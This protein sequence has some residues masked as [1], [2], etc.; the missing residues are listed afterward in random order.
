MACWNFPSDL[1]H[2][3]HWMF[4]PLSQSLIITF[5]VFRRFFVVVYSRSK[6]CGKWLLW[7][8]NN[9]PAVLWAVFNAFYS[10][11]SKVSNTLSPFL[12]FDFAGSS[13]AQELEIKLRIRNVLPVL[14]S[15]GQKLRNSRSRI[16]G[17]SILIIFIHYLYILVLS[18]LELVNFYFLIARL[19]RNYWIYIHRWIQE[20]YIA[21]NLFKWFL[22]FNFIK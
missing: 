2:T 12:F 10:N 17:T 3:P 22:F 21:F 20:L 14:G 8:I 1:Q 4:S 7:L 15:N 9:M 13:A 5:V 18:L 6:C 11:S 19:H 16:S